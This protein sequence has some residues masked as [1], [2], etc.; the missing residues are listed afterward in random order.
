MHRLLF[1]VLF[2]APAFAHDFWLEPSTFRPGV[3]ATFTMS[4]RVGENFEGDPVPRR[5]SRI[6]S[7]AVRTASGEQIVN[8][9][10]NQD[11]AGFVRIDEAGTA[12]I[13]Y[14]GAPYPHEVSRK[15]F[16]RFLREEGITNVR[17][18]GTTQKERYQRFAKCIVAVGDAVSPAPAFGFPLEI[19]IDGETVQVVLEGKPLPDVLVFALEQSGARLQQR[20]NAS[21]EAQFRFTPGVWLVKAVHVRAAPPGAGH[22]WDSLWASLTFQR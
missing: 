15:A 5:T 10:E 17:P 4:L 14:R 16:D 18:A 12:V 7:F 20:T 21:G 22:H 3:G 9:F 11:P 1:V 19:L 6:E 2:A 8:G 13:G